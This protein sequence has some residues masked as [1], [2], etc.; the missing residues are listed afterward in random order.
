MIDLRMAGRMLVVGVLLLGAAGCG[1]RAP[2]WTL[3]YI[4]NESRANGPQA[5][6]CNTYVFA[7][8][9]GQSSFAVAVVKGWNGSDKPTGISATMHTG[10]DFSG[11]LALGPTT[12][13]DDSN[14]YDLSVDVVYVV[15]PYV[16]AKARA[17][18]D[19]AL[20]G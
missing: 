10:E 6:P 7:R 3:W 20:R 4:P 17:D 8:S 13:H 16:A 2:K 14:G 15:G 1:Q 9:P 11:D 18:A 5:K 19:C 12:I